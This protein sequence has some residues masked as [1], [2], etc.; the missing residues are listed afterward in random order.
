MAMARKLA[1]CL[2]WIWRKG[3]NYELLIKIGSHAGKPGTGH[4]VKSN[5]E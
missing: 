3:W 5:T 4:G 2:Y 1:V